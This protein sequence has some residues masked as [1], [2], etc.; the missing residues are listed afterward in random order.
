MV[1]AVAYSQRREN[2]LQQT[3]RLKKSLPDTPKRKISEREEK[4][5]HLSCPL[6]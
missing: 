4:L 6:F 1:L 3:N 5:A 2:I